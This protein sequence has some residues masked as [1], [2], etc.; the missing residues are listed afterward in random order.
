MEACVRP[1]NLIVNHTRVGTHLPAMA[2]SHNAV[3]LPFI[4]RLC[5][6][7]LSCVSLYRRYAALAILGDF[8][9]NEPTSNKSHTSIHILDDDALLNVFYLYGLDV[10]DAEND[11]DFSVGKF[12]WKGAHW[13]YKLAH[14]CRRWRNVVVASPVHIGVHLLCTHGTP[15]ARMLAHSPPL[16]IIIYYMGNVGKPSSEDDENILL[17]LQHRERVRRIG[18]SVPAPSLLR[19][20][21][22]IDE[23]FPMLERLFI[24][25]RTIPTTSF[26][27]PE[28]FHAP[29]LRHLVLSRVSIQIGSPLLTTAAGLVTLKLACI[30]SSG[31]FD[32]SYLLA[33]LSLMS[34]LEI[35]AVAF[36][37]DDH[38]H[39]AEGQLSEN[40]PTTHVTLP[41]L[42]FFAFLGESA[43]LEGLLAQ[44]S[45]PALEQLRIESSTPSTLPQL[46]QFMGATD[47]LRFNTVRLKFL[48]DVYQIVLADDSHGEEWPDPFRMRIRC[49]HL[50]LQVA[51][52]V[53]IFREL[54]PL[55]F[56]VMTLTLDYE[57]LS[58]WF[59][60]REEVDRA[61]WRELLKPFSN[62]KTLLVEDGLLQ[63]GELL[64]S[65]Q[66]DS[67]EPPLPELKELVSRGGVGYPD[68]DAISFLNARQIAGYPV[69]LVYAR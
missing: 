32:P 57:V 46:S 3:C 64:R 37:S 60:W 26:S 17:A 58:P 50:D 10:W 48:R 51:S 52:A 21:T 20:I 61:L 13:W 31:Y 18:L 29:H 23:E 27:L 67:G 69:T 9:N 53:Q 59:D 33:R 25:P 54:W 40:Q 22:A 43:Y 34:R 56:V 63:G 6:H 11:D 62:V 55:L 39:D 66:S 14:V 5:R 36:H 7:S 15:V 4:G 68:D 44:I 35:L 1:V 2:H 49:R 47:N 41:C 19:L 24:S 45:T 8:L 38:N 28:S 30:P 16:P 42:R 12:H 65:L